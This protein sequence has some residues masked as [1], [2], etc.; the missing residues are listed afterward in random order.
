M[1]IWTQKRRKDRFWS[2]V[3]Q[4]NHSSPR[5]VCQCKLRNITLHY[6]TTLH[7]NYTTPMQDGSN[8]NF[9][10]WFIKAQLRKWTKPALIENKKKQERASNLNKEDSPLQKRYK[11]VLNILLNANFTALAF[12]TSPNNTIAAAAGNELEF[13]YL[14]ISRLCSPC[15]Y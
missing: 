15:N 13:Q 8:E 10:L 12:T 9:C 11:K 4:E 2:G 14:N 1:G 3:N 5:V 6:T 7:Y